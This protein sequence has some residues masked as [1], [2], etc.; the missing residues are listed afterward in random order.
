MHSSLY[1]LLLAVLFLALPGPASGRDPG[2][3]IVVLGSSTAAGTG[4]NPI[5][6]AWV[7]RFTKYILQKDSSAKVINLAVGGYTTYDIMPTGFVPPANRPGPKEGHNITSALSYHPDVLIIN[8]PSNDAA[9]G[10]S[11]QEQLANYSLIV[12]QLTD[13]ETRL[14]VSTTQPRNFADSSKVQT[15]VEMRDS[16][17]RRFGPR[18]MDFWTDLATPDGTLKKE[19]DSGDGIH[20]NNAGHWILFE[21]ALR[22]GAA[23]AFSSDLRLYQVH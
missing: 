4:A 9:S 7:W 16:T 1:S 5:D 12:A 22:A 11:V 15:Q 20:L 2:P 14:F 3:V 19:Y 10:Y 8:L 17:I 21:R 6:S 23:G 18:T 13:P